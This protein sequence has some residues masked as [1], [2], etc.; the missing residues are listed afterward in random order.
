MTYNKLH[1]HETDNVVLK[2]TE[3]NI[4]KSVHKRCIQD[5]HE[6]ISIQTDKK[7]NKIIEAGA[8]R[9][10]LMNFQSRN[11]VYLK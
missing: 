10:A 9:I 11:T 6:H 8:N 7:T 2:N 4:K 3:S 1:M 5:V